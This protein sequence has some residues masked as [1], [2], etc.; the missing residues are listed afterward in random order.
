MDA[1]AQ[2]LLR[3]AQPE[4]CQHRTIIVDPNKQPPSFWQPG[5]WQPG[6]WKTGRT[7]FV[8]MATSPLSLPNEL[9]H[10][11]VLYLDRGSLISLAQS[12]RVL[13]A[14]AVQQLHRN[15]PRLSGPNTIRCLNTLATSPDIA[16]KVR[17]FNIYSSFVVGLSTTALSPAPIRPPGKGVWNRL[18]AIFRPSL[19]PL[20]SPPPLAPPRLH[21]IAGIERISLQTTANAFYNM[22]NLHTLIIHAPS[23]PKLWEFEHPIPTLRTIF[24]HLNAESPSLFAWIMTQQ[25]I[26]SL[27]INDIFPV[28]VPI[29]KWYSLPNLRDL[30][31]K[32]PGVLY[33]FP[34]GRVSELIIDDLFDISVVD[35]LATVIP[36]SS[37]KSGIHL[38]RL[39]AYGTKVAINRLLDRLGHLLTHLLFLRIFMVDK[40]RESV[41]S[42]PLTMTGPALTAI[43][44]PYR[45]VC[46]SII[47]YQSSLVSRLL[48]F[49]PR[50]RMLGIQVRLSKPPD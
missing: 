24:V 38:R 41:S 27:R 25:S 29:D 34:D 11:I 32:P 19:P 48:S 18:L 36:S 45:N 50:R 20:P 28:P 10:D 39:T 35:R 26:T 9:L 22:K 3:N 6:F 30:T 2:C 8:T 1:S 17:T 40:P 14:V 31:C 7:N 47:S 4:E 44:S 16:G 37:A 42:I 15:V 33:L 49:S 12:C 13:H 23:H 21:F 46:S 5:F 43:N